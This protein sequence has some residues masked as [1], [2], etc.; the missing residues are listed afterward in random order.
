MKKKIIILMLMIIPVFSMTACFVDNSEKDEEK[1]NE[2]AINFKKDYESI[3]GV[4][5]TSGV[6]RSVTISEDN[7]F[8]E[9]TPEE[10]VKKIENK[11]SFYVYFGSNLCPWCRSVIEKADA[12]SRDNDIER[13]YYVDIW[14][15]KGNEILRD[16]YLVDENNN[17]VVVEEGTETYKKL[18]NLLDEQLTEYTLT[19]EN[20]NKVE[21]SEKR[22][23]APTYFYIEKGKAIKSTTGISPKQTNSRAELTEEM[24]LDQENEFK[25]LFNNSCDIDRKC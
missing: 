5:T 21:T 23:Y 13:I 15:D 14:D 25:K 17:P 18:L 24:L 11:E 4:E 9:T 22:I 10:I 8:I 12:V 2:N 6:H 19:D 20:G 7:R 1:V 16:K 3:N